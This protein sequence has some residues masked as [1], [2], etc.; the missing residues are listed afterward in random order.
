M[1]ARRLGIAGIL[2]VAVSL[3]AVR[4]FLFHNL[5]YQI[6]FVRHHR[7]V[8]YAH[9]LFRRWTGNMDLDGLILLKWSLALAMVALMLGLCIAL[10]RVLFGDHRYRVPLVAGFGATGGL[11]LVLHLL[12]PMAP[13]LEG[14]SIKLLHLLQYPVVLFLVWAASLLPRRRA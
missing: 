4:E 9:S 8:S 3:G 1:N 12:A 5:N 6:D 11:A 10:A 14:V 13:P 7:E 2:A